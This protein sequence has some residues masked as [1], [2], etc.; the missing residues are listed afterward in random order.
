LLADIGL[1]PDQLYDVADRIGLRAAANDNE[2][3]TALSRL[4]ANDNNVKPCA[5]GI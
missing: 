4:A 2:L 5:D 1:H 3:P